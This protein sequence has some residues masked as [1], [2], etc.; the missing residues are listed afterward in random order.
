[1]FNLNASIV[2]QKN[3]LA[4]L[5][6]ITCRTVRNLEFSCLKK[7]AKFA[8]YMKKTKIKAPP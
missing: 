5:G 2:Q 6:E 1:M 8:P 7:Y 3:Q 4:K